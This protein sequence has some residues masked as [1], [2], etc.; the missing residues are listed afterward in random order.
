MFKCTVLIKQN[1]FSRNLPLSRSK[2]SCR[3]GKFTPRSWNI[4]SISAPVYH[5]FTSLQYFARD[6]A[7]TLFCN[8]FASYSNNMLKTTFKFL[9]FT[10]LNQTETCRTARPLS[11]PN[12]TA[13]AKYVTQ[14]EARIK[15]LR[16]VKQNIKL[17]NNSLRNQLFDFDERCPWIY[18]N[19]S[20]SVTGKQ[21]FKFSTL[22]DP[23][24]S[25]LT[26]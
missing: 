12:I 10:E 2:I 8:S 3:H 14:R 7:T 15:L 16:T 23:T 20:Q 6:P 24:K 25:A 13:C 18:F 17:I 5:E 19:S 21:T 4:Q 26:C 22:N 9:R 1:R 11:Q